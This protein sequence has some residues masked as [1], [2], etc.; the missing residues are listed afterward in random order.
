[1]TR[2]QAIIIAVLAG[3]TGLAFAG[4]VALVALPGDFFLVETPTPTPT[5]IVVATRVPTVAVLPTANTITPTPADPTPTNTRLP[6]STPRPTATATERA[7]FSLPT[8]FPTRTPT[9]IPPPPPEATQPP[10]DTVVTPVGPLPAQQ[11][12]IYF[13]S[14]DSIIVLG[15]CTDLEWDVSG[16]TSVQLNGRTEPPRGNREVCPER[17]SSYELSVQIPNTLQIERRIV[18]IQVQ[19]DPDLVR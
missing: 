1:M 5:P 6:T 14:D 13:S 4:M 9:P 17:D 8:P 16:V 2:T 12:R 3:F 18:E 10:S 15:E 19:R 11:Y 7:E